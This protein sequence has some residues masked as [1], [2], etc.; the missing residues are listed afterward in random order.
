MLEDYLRIAGS[1]RF[2]HRPFAWFGEHSRFDGYRGY[3]DFHAGERRLEPQDAV[4][5]DVSPVVNA[6]TADVGYTLC[7]ERNTEF[8]NGLWGG[9]DAGQRG[10]QVGSLSDRTP[11]WLARRRSEI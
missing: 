8:E 9:T 11:Y 10:I 4:I 7:L 3:G 6:Y 5:L 1:E 2:I